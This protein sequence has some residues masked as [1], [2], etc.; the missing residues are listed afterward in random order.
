MPWGLTHLF[1]GIGKVSL[2]NQTV[3]STAFLAE[4]PTAE[5]RRGAKVFVSARIEL[6]QELTANRS[7]TCSVGASL[8]RFVSHDVS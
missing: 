2:T 1:I 3:V 7:V 5:N 4:K 6:C 8:Y